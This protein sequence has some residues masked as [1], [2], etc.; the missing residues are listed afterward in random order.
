MHQTD[1][2]II[3]A[4]QWNEH[5]IIG[6]ADGWVSWRS[7]EKKDGVGMA[8]H[9]DHPQSPDLPDR[10]TD[11]PTQPTLINCYAAG[12]LIITMQAGREGRRRILS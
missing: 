2:N 4:D 8:V 10:P 5:T 1:S 9:A 6:K 7:F 3:T 12:R 11:R